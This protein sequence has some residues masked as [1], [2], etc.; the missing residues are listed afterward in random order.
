MAQNSEVSASRRRRGPGRPFSRGV[1][2]NPGGRPRAAL[3]VQALAREHTPQA[4]ATLVKALDNERL[5][6]SAAVH[7]LDRAW[8]K[9]AALL[10]LEGADRVTSVV[11]NIVSVR[12]QPANDADMPRLITITAGDE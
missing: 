2:G 12:E 3:D 5:C 7:L 1:S 4:I 6:V 10:D 8:G 11:L 9:P